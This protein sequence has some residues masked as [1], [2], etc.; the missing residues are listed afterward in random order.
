[1]RIAIVAGI[2]IAAIIVT[3]TQSSVRQTVAID[4]RCFAR[5]MSIITFGNARIAGFVLTAKKII[6]QFIA[7]LA[8]LIIA[9]F[10]LPTPLTKVKKSVIN[11]I[12]PP[13]KKFLISET[14]VIF[15]HRNVIAS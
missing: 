5:L 7:R 1:M 9:T 11:A 15:G 6:T 10:E 13:T 2:L 8:E 14:F 12:T 4:A 3:K